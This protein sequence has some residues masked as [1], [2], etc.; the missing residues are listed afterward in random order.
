[1]TLFR[2]LTNR[3][4]ILLWI[5]Q[6]TSSI[7]DFLYEIVLAWWVL[8]QTGSALMMGA[9]LTCSFVP[10][11]LCS[12]LGGAVVDRVPRLHV[13]LASDLVRGL[14][15]AGVT[16]LALR[17]SLQVW[18]VLIASVMFGT[19]EAF[20]RPAYAALVPELVPAQDLPSANAL[21]GLS[22]QIGR[23][24]G[25][26]LGATVIALVGTSGAFAFNGATFFISAACLL[27]LLSSASSPRDAAAPATNLLHDVREGI[28]TVLQSPVLWITIGVSALIN[29]TLAGP[30]SVAMP[31]LVKNHLAGDVGALGLLYAVFPIG[32]I[33]GGIWLGRLGAIRHR[34][35][36]VY[37]G[38]MLAGLMLALFGLTVP[39]LVLVVAAIVNGAA[40]GVQSQVWTNIL[41]DVVPSERLG[42]VASIDSLGSFALLP[43]G[44]AIAGWATD[45]LGP[46]AIFTLGGG[47][48]ALIALVALAHPAIRTFD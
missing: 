9:V 18:H 47:M 12:L 39:L 2:A 7:G 46:A 19:I 32:Y 28:D 44:F 48:T 1:M 3:S 25:P 43:L 33:L 36:M 20:F 8:Q 42:R 31:L 24:A 4:F 27:P 22:L 38:L 34:G 26:A 45:L 10:M 37:L 11:V 40:L 14:I 6:L 17:Q 23:I 35:R 16:S 5:G 13:M 41:Q 15:V 29:I 30:Y 21:T